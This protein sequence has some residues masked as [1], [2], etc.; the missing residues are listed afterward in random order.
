[1]TA[2]PDALDA[3]HTQPGDKLDKRTMAI[4]WVVVIGSVM[5]ILDA[6]IVNV[7]I[8]RL[9]DEFNSTLATIQ[10]VVTG[11]MLALATVI[12][13]TGWAIHRF[14]TKRLY[15]VSIALFMGGSALA[16]L[17]WSDTSL[18]VFRVLQGF[19]GGMIMPAGM[20]ILTQAAGPARV[21]RVMAIVGVPMMIGPICGPILGG[22]L[23]DD[24]SWR[25]IFMVNV[26]VGLVALYMAQ[27]ILPSDRPE[28]RHPLDWLGVVLL[29]PGLASLIYGLAK[30]AQ[31]GGF[32]TAETNVTTVVGAVLV[33][34]FVVHALRAREPL[35][36]LRLFA[37]RSVGAAALAMTLFTLAFF[38]AMLLLPLYF[39]LVRHE[40]AL[41]S[42][43]LLAPQG[44][45]AM[46]AMPVGGTLTDRL[47]PGRF[48]LGGIVTI[49]ATFI[50]LTQ[51]GADTS[52]VT[53]SIALFIMG[54]G[55]GFT[56]MPIMSAALQTLHNDEVPRASTALNIIQQVGGA[57]GTAI[58]SVILANSLAD[59]LTPAVVVG[60]GGGAP[61]QSGSDEGGIA[62]IH[63][64]PPDAFKHLA[65]RIA[66][67][68]GSTLWWAV[69]FLIASLLPSLLLP[70]RRPTLPTDATGQMEGLADD[71][72]TSLAPPP[73]LMH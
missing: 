14:G 42:G 20:T 5:A 29:S 10:W 55:M 32:K 16:G 9:A 60:G 72:D 25:W 59:R 50:Y 56:M 54:V 13:L 67:A 36:D 15:L 19:G 48:V 17:A 43:L 33:G 26:P 46:L 57:I 61:A 40:S 18:I 68:F 41:M 3:A 23:V 69:A 35:L 37:R 53:I 64:L 49:I 71:T 7:A 4:A 51:L 24:F 73:T 38:G 2:H 45:G 8:T 11:Y 65:P 28:G 70:M 27:R 62:A 1:M 52:Y 22:W 31:I 30:M 63:A 34:A 21:G 66:D 6:T 44:F 39:Q 12:P 58:L 47:G